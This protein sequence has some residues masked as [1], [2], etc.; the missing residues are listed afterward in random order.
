M[1]TEGLLPTE[2][3]TPIPLM[4]VIATFEV[5]AEDFMLG[6]ALATRP[7]IRVRVERVVPLSERT[8]PYLWVSDDSAEA[9]ETA[10]RAEANVESLEI[11]DRLDGD[12]LVRVAWRATLDGLLDAIVDVGGTILDA[13]GAAGRWSLTIQ[14][15]DR[16]DLGVF[17]RHCADRGIPLDVVRVHDPDPPDA[18]AA[19][20]GLTETQ[21]R[22][23]QA[24]LEAGYFDV[25]RRANLAALAAELGVSDTAVSQRLRRGISALLQAT[26][27]SSARDR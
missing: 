5:A 2:S 24:A 15:D 17:Y 22:T 3:R 23:L 25:P 14:F 13:V 26:L 20:L 19:G 21:Y 6:D 18:N 27:H 8:I 12:F 16:M 11:V 4:S 9:V 1:S 7:G 10:L